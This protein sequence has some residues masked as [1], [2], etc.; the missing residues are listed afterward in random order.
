MMTIM[1]IKVIGVIRYGVL[2]LVIVAIICQYLS[3]RALQ[4]EQANVI[5]LVENSGSIII[6]LILQIIVFKVSPR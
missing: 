2:F 1:V 5:S 3:I 4:I 6:S